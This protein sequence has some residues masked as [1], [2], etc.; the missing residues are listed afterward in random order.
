MK[1]YKKEISAESV[2]ELRSRLGIDALTASILLRRGIHEGEEALYYLEEDPR[3][4]HNPFLFKDMEDAVDRILAAAEEGEKVMVFGDRD[5]DGVTGTA[6]LLG[7]LAEL[8]IEAEARLPRGDEAY[9]LSLEALEDFAARDGTLVIT[10]DNGISCLAEAEAAGRLGLDLIVV[11]HHNPLPELPAALAVINPKCADSGYPFRDLCGCAVAYKLAQALRFART[12]P[13]K[14]RVCLLNARPVNEAIAVDAVLYANMVPLRRMTEFLMPGA[15]QPER[16]RLVP[17]LSDKRIL[18][19]DAP[20]QR[21]LLRRALGTGIE[22][23]MYDV[24]DEVAAAIPQ[25]AGQSLLRLREAS[26]LARYRQREGADPEME[27]FESIFVSW[28][29]KSARGQSEAELMD[30]QLAAL[31]TIAD[32]MPLRGENRILV[33]RGLKAMA[34]RPRPGLAELLAAAELGGRRSGGRISARDISFQLSPLVNSAGRLGRPEIALEL[35]RAEDGARRAG[36]VGELM[37]MNQER[38]AMGEQSWE[39]ARPEAE[40]SLQAHAGKLAL[41]C[42]QELSRGVTGIIATRVSKALG[43][44]AIACAALADGTVSGS[45]RSARGLDVRSF[46][47]A[48][49]D[50]F[51]DFGGHDYAAG[52]SM[53]AERTP[54]FR[55]RL[56]ALAPTIEFRDQAE[57]S[58]DIDAELPLDYLKPELLELAERFE[59]SGEDSPPAT[60]L[61]RGLSIVSMEVMGKREP[62]HLRLV[63]DSGR[64]K[65]PAVYW[66]AAERAGRDLRA[67]QRVDAVFSM[68]RD[69]FSGTD[70]PRLTI[71]DI[72]DHAAREGTTER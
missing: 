47:E 52:F 16:T 55:E 4:L 2:Q 32:M 21:R 23:A 51:I 33:K 46:L 1:W 27:T 59:P 63:L 18:V 62:M 69:N 10:V 72:K 3:Y 40:A 38:R 24:R 64:H 61:A 14:E 48:F 30:C 19:W 5:T 39:S 60:F 54:E 25:T 58:L 70:L 45:M 67:G 17:F 8:G 49:Q 65:W 66:Q 11:D 44:P 12:G 31:G 41:V 22:V 28:A 56:A 37:A 71:L 43:V 29:L 36:L 50:I 42:G 7:I 34:Q 26:R 6:L 68:A 35:F 9:G 53:H 20:L 15:V 57:E 13:Y